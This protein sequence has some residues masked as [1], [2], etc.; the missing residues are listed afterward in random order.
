MVITYDIAN[1]IL[2]ELTRMV[3]LP[4]YITNHK[5]IIV[6]GYNKAL[7]G[8]EI[9]SAQIAISQNDKIELQGDRPPHLKGIVFPIYF[10]D[11]C[12][13]ATIITDDPKRYEEY[14]YILKFSIEA[15]IEKCVQTKQGTNKRRMIETW[16][17]NLFDE[18]YIDWD[19]MQRGAQTLGINTNAASTIVVMNVFAKVNMVGAL[20]Y[21]DPSFVEN[22]IVQNLV[23]TIKINFFSYLGRNL[24]A[25][26]IE[27]NAARTRTRN[28]PRSVLN[29]ALTQ[30]NT[31]FAQINMS[32]MIGIGTT[33]S[34]LQGYRN[35]FFQAKKS[36]ELAQR[37]GSQS[38]VM[39]I[40]DWG[41]L[42]FLC[43]TP[44]G[45]AKSLV[46]QYLSATPNF[47]GEMV[48]TMQLFFQ[49]NC[50]MQQTADSLQIHKNTLLYRLKRV[51]ELYGLDPQNFQ[52][53]VILQLLLHMKR[54][55]PDIVE[56]AADDRKG[57]L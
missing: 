14:V 29:E 48:E 13:G 43:Q 34:T 26:S 46:S 32:C 30:L 10:Y 4:L 18:E 39:H 24:Y 51:K 19:E 1:Y 33:S 27:A 22:Y 38:P 49:K 12:V 21:N 6:T 50:A 16:I 35:S 52:D 31:E 3:D 44:K 40:Y 8:K 57:L 9:P 28:M 15:L 41:I 36:I 53:A 11:N 17:A 45:I 37:L 47:Q 2:E 55:Y 23:N 5:G 54:L 7:I 25:F 20:A 42:Y 56:A